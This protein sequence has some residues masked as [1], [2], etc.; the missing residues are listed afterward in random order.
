[1]VVFQ[2]LKTEKKSQ[3][4]NTCANVIG[5]CHYFCFELDGV[6][7]VFQCQHCGVC[8]I[9]RILVFKDFGGLPPLKNNDYSLT[10]NMFS[11]NVA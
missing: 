4:L 11:R 3:L 2:D 9:F 8:H 7:H 1:M 5:V 6:C 10:G